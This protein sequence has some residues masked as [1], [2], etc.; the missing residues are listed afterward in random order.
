[1]RRVGDRILI[2]NMA[3]HGHE[4]NAN[5]EHELES[6]A[7]HQVKAF[8]RRFGELEFELENTWSGIIGVSANGAQCFGQPAANLF[9]S[10]GYNG[11]GIAQG[12]ISGRLLVDLALGRK[13]EQLAMI[14][15]LRRPAW[16]PTGSLLKMG[17]NAYLNF[18][19]WR[20]S[21]EI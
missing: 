3:V 2:R 14:Q 15:R 20:F 5:W 7:N 21:E 13:S 4:P 11:H 10:C 9:V 6:M 17:V 16:I 19:S 12:T 8:R 1:M 18:L